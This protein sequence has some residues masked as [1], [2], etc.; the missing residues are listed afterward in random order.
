M[1]QVLD[2]GY[3][4]LVDT[5]GSDLT[6]VNAARA[7]Y[8][9]ESIELNEKDEGLIKFLAK[10]DHTS[11]FRHAMLQFEVY[12]PLMVARQW[13]KYIIGSSHLE[14]IGDTMNGWNES[15]RRYVTQEPVFYIPK[16]DE[17]RAK[18]DNNKQGSKEPVDVALGKEFTE[19]LLKSVD[20]GIKLYEEAMEKG[21]CA[22]EARLFLPAYGMYV[23]W[24]WTAS[25]QS[26]AHFIKQRMDSHSQY[27]IRQYAA[28]VKEL[29]EE[30][31]PLSIKA[32]LE[33]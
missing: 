31:F 21:I 30:K 27:E 4:R 20:E 10:N 25:L 12:A 11:P 24:Y 1:K 9:K 16:E 29:A 28:A 14:G 6:V 3:V 19:K 7:S 13:W 22:E 15:S 8:A 26:V 2:K 33:K 18:P 32:L 17:W 23:S 5:M